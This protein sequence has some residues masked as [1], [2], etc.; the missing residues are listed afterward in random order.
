[1]VGERSHGVRHCFCA[2]ICGHEIIC[3]VSSG[4]CSTTPSTTPMSVESTTSNHHEAALHEFHERL[5]HTNPHGDGYIS[6]KHYEQSGYFLAGGLASV[7]SRTLTAP[8]DRLKIYLISETYSKRP[9]WQ[10]LKNGRLLK[11]AQSASNG[12]TDAS[13]SIWQAGG[14]RSLWAGNGINIVK[15][16]PEG[17][18]KFGVYEVRDAVFWSL[19][20]RHVR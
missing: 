15:M 18:I 20:I 11:A 2:C 16:L 14:V 8:I 1:M 19:T 4:H 10:Y 9:T 6:E 12:L 3:S 17:A 5:V 7:T 13:K